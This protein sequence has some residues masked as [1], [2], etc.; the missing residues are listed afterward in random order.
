MKTGK[1]RK[2]RATPRSVFDKAC[3]KIGEHIFNSFVK[4]A[5][6]D[7]SCSTFGFLHSI[8]DLIVTDGFSA[9][10]FI[11]SLSV[12]SGGGVEE[13]DKSGRRKRG[14]YPK[15]DHKKVDQST[16]LLEIH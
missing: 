12:A 14:P 5:E 10:R 6:W 7:V 11:L 8:L 1:N 16:T 13:H 4:R 2:K 15:T 9:S 3:E